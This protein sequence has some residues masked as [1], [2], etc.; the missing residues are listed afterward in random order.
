MEKEVGKIK[1]MELCLI[2]IFVT[3]LI[4]SIYYNIASLGEH[5]GYDSSWS[6]LKAGL[7]W[8]EK[9][10]AS[11]MWAEQTNL[12]LDSTMLPAAFLYGMTGNLLVSYGISNNIVLIA[13]IYCMSDIV[14][15]LQMRKSVRLICL[16]LLICPYMVNGFARLIPGLFNELGY[17]NCLIS[18]P[19]FYSVVVLLFL[20]VVS[21]VINL[22]TEKNHMSV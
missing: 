14:K 9:A 12:F 3:Q 17:F 7:M 2:L 1:R 5:M 11:E 20:M 6:Y 8:R 21:V 10:F 4:I 22:K 18:G 16:N 15:E 13:I 19:A